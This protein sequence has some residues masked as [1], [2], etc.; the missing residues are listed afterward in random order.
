MITPCQTR[1]PRLTTLCLS[2]AFAVT[3]G[4]GATLVGLDALGDWSA[5]DAALA[6]ATADQP[7]IVN[8]ARDEA[9]LR[10]LSEQ[11]MRGSDVGEDAGALSAIAPAAGTPLGQ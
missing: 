5:R 11:L 7:Y 9:L 8:I 4:I 1:K 6:S 10:D 2:A 3:L